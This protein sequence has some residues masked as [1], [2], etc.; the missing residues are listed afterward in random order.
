M[1]AQASNSLWN[2]II[3]KHNAEGQIVVNDGLSI[4]EDDMRM[5]IHLLHQ[6]KTTLTDGAQHMLQKYYVISRKERPSK[7]NSIKQQIVFLASK[8]RVVSVRLY[9]TQINKHNNNHNSNRSHP[10]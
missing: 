3:Q 1:G 7:S 4:P 9:E 10:N 8:R 2:S 5:L 6:R